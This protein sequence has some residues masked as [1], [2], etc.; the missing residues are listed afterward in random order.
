MNNNKEEVLHTKGEFYLATKV[1]S[2]LQLRILV[3]NDKGIRWHIADCFSFASNIP[4]EEAQA[5]AVFIVKAVNSHELLKDVLQM[6]IDKRNNHGWDAECCALL[7][8]A[9]LKKIESK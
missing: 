4:D 8:E 7:A 3:D 6:I 9:V 5:N 2:D 1:G